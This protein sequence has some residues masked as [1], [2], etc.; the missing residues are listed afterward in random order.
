MSH[1]ACPRLRPNQVVLNSAG[2]LWAARKGKPQLG[3]AFGSDVVTD[4]PQVLVERLTVGEGGTL[5][6]VHLSLR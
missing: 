3:L 2:E 4:A 6:P 1:C 5:S